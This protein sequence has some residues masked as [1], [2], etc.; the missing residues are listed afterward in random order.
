[1]SQVNLDLVTLLLAMVV[2]VAFVAG[3]KVGNQ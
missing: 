1:M 3:V 2:A